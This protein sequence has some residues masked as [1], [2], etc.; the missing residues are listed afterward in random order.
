MAG[1]N[2]KSFRELEQELAHVLS[3][4]EQAEYD[5]LDELLKDYEV[6]K[7][8]IDELEKKLEN[9]KNSIKKVTKA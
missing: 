4:V 1:K 9:A 5:E 2:D 6:G 7:K 3:R 8:L